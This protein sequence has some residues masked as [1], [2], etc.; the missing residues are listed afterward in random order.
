MRDGRA[1][2]RDAVSAYLVSEVA[3]HD[4]VASPVAEVDYEAYQ[5]PDAEPQPVLRGQREHQKQAGRYPRD[6]DEGDERRAERAHGV[7]GRAPHDE[8]S[9]ADDDEGEERPDVEEVGE[10]PERQ[11]RREKRHEDARQDG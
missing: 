8:N 6:G 3:R 11:Q 10:N 4:A 5:K 7:G 2:G 1:R 9:R